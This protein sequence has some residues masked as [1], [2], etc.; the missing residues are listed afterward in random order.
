MA[1]LQDE[2]VTAI[3]R[4][5][6]RAKGQLAA[7]KEKSQA[8]LRTG[9]NIG[10]VGAGAL[11]F[12]YLNARYGNDPSGTY[13]Q[14]MGVPVDLAAAV[15]LHGLA[16]FGMAGGY[17]EDMHML[18][19]GA[20]ASYLARLGGQLG[21]QGA[22]GGAAAA[23]KGTFGAGGYAAGGLPQGGQAPQGATRYVVTEV[24][25]YGS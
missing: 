13:Y 8:M 20:I 14:L 15:V 18:G 7:N 6:D 3:A 23:T 9:L 21:K 17:E 12:S 24:P 1:Y 19:T 4:E 25:S 11:G 5:L 10:E 22:S 16:F 2:T